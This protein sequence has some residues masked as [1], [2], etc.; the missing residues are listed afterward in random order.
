MKLVK[1]LFEAQVGQAVSA[2]ASPS[3]VGD[4]VC[5]RGSRSSSLMCLDGFSPGRDGSKALIGEGV[6]IHIFRFCPTNSFEIGLISKELIGQ[7]L[8]I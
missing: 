1:C 7:N 6:Y 8:N 5:E 3:L 2:F 4:I